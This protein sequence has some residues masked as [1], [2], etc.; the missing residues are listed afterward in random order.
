MYS[1]IVLSMISCKL[2]SS[3]HFCHNQLP[4]STELHYI[5]NG[6]IVYPILYMIFKQCLF[7]QANN[8]L[9]VN[10]GL[11]HRSHSNITV[12]IVREPTVKKRWTAW[13]FLLKILCCPISIMELKQMRSNNQTWPNRTVGY[14]S[15][16]YEAQ[17]ASWRA[18]GKKSEA[19]I[20]IFCILLAA[21]RFSRISRKVESHWGKLESC[22]GKSESHWRK[23][24]AV[25]ESGKLLKKI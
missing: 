8:A 23:R 9:T 24:K 16:Y 25:E 19:Q 6:W 18:S 4:P 7:N 22:W 20:V 13:A 3:S 21:N 11:Q 10:A 5:F 15:R 14:C 2:K 12:G 1:S 17:R